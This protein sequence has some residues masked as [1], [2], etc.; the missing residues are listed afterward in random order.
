MYKLYESPV[1]KKRLKSDPAYCKKKLDKVTIN[2]TEKLLDINAVQ[3]ASDKDDATQSEII[4]QLK[5][6]FMK[7]KY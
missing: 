2:L 4:A 1:V 6:K 5:E 3:N 7:T